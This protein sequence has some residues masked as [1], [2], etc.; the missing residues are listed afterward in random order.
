MKNILIL[1]AATFMLVAMVMTSGCTLSKQGGTELYPEEETLTTVPAEKH[2]KSV[3]KGHSKDPNR[4][5]GTEL[6]PEE[7]TL[8]TV[9]AEKHE[10]PIPEGHSKDPNRQGGTELYPEED[11]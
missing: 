8:F 10:K 5:G 11:M 7:E 4:Q 3:P 6:Y 9:P 2:E 1:A